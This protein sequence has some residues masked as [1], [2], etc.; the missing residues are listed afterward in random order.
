MANGTKSRSIKRLLHYSDEIENVGRS[1]GEQE[2]VQ[3]TDQ[4]VLN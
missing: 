1:R 3:S 2:D 4:S